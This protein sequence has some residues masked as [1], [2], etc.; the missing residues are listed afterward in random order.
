M[1]IIVPVNVCIKRYYRAYATVDENATDEQIIESVR[2]HILNNDPDV[3]LNPDLDL[4]IYEGDIVFI[5]PDC[6]ESWTEEEDK[7]IH[8]ILEG[9]NED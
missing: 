3:E 8:E 6:G 4:E 2:E 7:D 9:W 5:E 1:K